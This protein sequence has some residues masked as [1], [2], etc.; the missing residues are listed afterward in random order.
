MNMKRLFHFL[1]FLFFSCAFT[2]YGQNQV[3]KN[4]VLIII[5]DLSADPGTRPALQMP[6]ID[7]LRSKGMS[8]SS[9]HAASPLC[10]PS[11]TAAFTGIAPWQSKIYTNGAEF[12]EDETYGN[13]V[14]LPQFFKNQGYISIGTGKIFH[15]STGKG[16]D[17]ASWTRNLTQ[18][19][20]LYESSENTAAPVSGTGG[21]LP[22]YVEQVPLAWGQ[23][24]KSTSQMDDWSNLQPALSFLKGQT[25]G[26][27][28]FFLACG[29]VRPHLPHVYPREFA[30]HY[31]DIQ[32]PSYL[33]PGSS[34]A[35]TW[36]TPSKGNQ[37]LDSLLALPNG[38]QQ[39][40]Q[41]VQ[42]YLRAAAFAD[43]CVGT[44]LEAIES[45]PEPVRQNTI[46]VLMGDHG[47]HLG[48][49]SSWAKVGNGWN[50]LPWE[51]TTHTPLVIYDPAQT[52]SHG[53]SYALPVSLQDIYPTLL[54]LCDYPPAQ[55]PDNDP[56]S[57]KKLWG[58]SL[59]PILKN[60]E[61]AHDTYALSTLSAGVVSL[62]TREWR[63]IQMPGKPLRELY[64][65]GNNPSIAPSDPGE[66]FNLLHP[67]HAKPLYRKIAAELDTRVK[68]IMKEGK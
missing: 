32:L 23:L 28:A 42:S 40:K 37:A 16:C 18:V 67:A 11:R 13:A 52:A 57:P 51:Q 5:D 53:K 19:D 59:A 60:P 50:Q 55:F 30:D 12:R 62:R 38:A 61:G 33:E 14:T 20:V 29:I 15:R 7:Q 41:A 63:Y 8:F 27:S 48:Q 2:L 1:P 43:S 26:D 54:E 45:L 68:E 66:H 46:V 4:I 47:Y 65:H 44:L 25:P 17:P 21:S 6:H 24:E 58:N 3:Q 34:K 36:D 39:W 9:A 22:A 49:K 31:S 35:D 56:Q 10:N 64:Y